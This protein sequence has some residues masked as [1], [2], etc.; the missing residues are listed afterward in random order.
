M[1]EGGTMINGRWYSNHSLERMAP[2][3]PEVRAEL[4][5]RAM[6]RAEE[7]GLVPG[8]RAFNNFVIGEVNPRNIPPMVV[9]DAIRNTPAIPGSSPGTFQHQ[10]PDVTIIVNSNGDVVTV[11]PR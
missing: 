5:T 10:T 2:N 9:E 11:I 8:T 4:Y 6:R 1:I 3:T 7:R